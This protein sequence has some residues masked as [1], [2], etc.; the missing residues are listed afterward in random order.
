MLGRAL[1][2]LV[3]FSTLGIIV[4]W[5][6]GVRLV[7]SAEEGVELQGGEG[8]RDEDMRRLEEAEER[9]RQEEE[10]DDEEEEEEGAGGGEVGE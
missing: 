8:E 9:A 1:S 4:R 2:Y 3:L 6:I 5:S 7:S 10:E